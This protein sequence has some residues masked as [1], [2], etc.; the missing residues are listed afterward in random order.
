[1]SNVIADDVLVVPLI[2]VSEHDD[3]T[4]YVVLENGTEKTVKL[5]RTTLTHA[6][7]LEGLDAGAT[8]RLAHQRGANEGS[9][10]P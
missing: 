5:G 9:K 7:V 1:M 2:A 10:A 6:E 8:V 4:S 3:G